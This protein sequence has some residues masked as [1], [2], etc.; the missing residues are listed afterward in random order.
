MTRARH[1]DNLIK[2][3]NCIENYLNNKRLKNNEYQDIVLLAEELREAIKCIGMITGSITNEDVLD[4][5]FR[6]FCIGK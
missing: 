1:R 3:L 2:C 6:D 4:V 5:I